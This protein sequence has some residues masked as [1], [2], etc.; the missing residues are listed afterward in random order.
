MRQEL[1]SGPPEDNNSVY[2]TQLMCKGILVD[3]TAAIT[4][5]QTSKGLIQS[6]CLLQFMSFP[7]LITVKSSSELGNS[8]AH[9]SYGMSRAY[10]GQSTPDRGVVA[11]TELVP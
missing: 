4:V 5:H 8:P 2:Q 11:A 6:V 3:T 1:P 9:N 7:L 10:L